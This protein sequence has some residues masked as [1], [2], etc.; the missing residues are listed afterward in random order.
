MQARPGPFW[1]GVQGRAPVPPAAATLGFEFVGA[2]IEAGTIELAFAATGAF[3]NPAGNV[4]GGFLAAMLFDTEARPQALTGWIR[5]NAAPLDTVDPTA[6]LGDLLPPVRRAGGVPG[7]RR[8][9][10]VRGAC[11]RGADERHGVACGRR[12]PAAGPPLHRPDAARPQRAPAA[13][14]GLV[15]RPGPLRLHRLPVKAERAAS[16]PAPAWRQNP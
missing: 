10:P 16:D 4:L 8:F 5:D 2:D 11:S 13:P 3:T 7:H 1:D 9:R 14:P 12:R 6:P 15:R